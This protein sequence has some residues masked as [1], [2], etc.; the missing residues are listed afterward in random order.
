MQPDYLYQLLPAIY[1]QQDAAKGE[2]LRAL[3]GILQQALQNVY[4]DIATSYN[5]AFIETCA[6]WAIPYI[7]DLLGITELD[8]ELLSVVDQ[9]ARVANTIRYRRRKGQAAITEQVINSVT[10]W[11]A[12]LVEFFQKLAITQDLH[13]IRPGVG[14]TASIRDA[15]AMLALN[16]PFDQS[17]H[18][19]EICGQSR[20]LNYNISS[21][22][23]Y[24]W[25]LQ[26]NSIINSTVYAIDPKNKPGCYT[27]N[28]V[29]LDMP[30]FN[31][32]QSSTKVTQRASAVNLPMAISLVNLAKDFENN[33]TASNYYGKD[34]SIYLNDP[35]DTENTYLNNLSNIVA[36]DLSNWTKPPKGKVAIDPQLG[37]ICFADDITPPK[38]LQVNY[39]FGFG[40]DLGGGSYDRHTSMAS[41]D[42]NTFAATVAK[43]ESNNSETTVNNYP[44]INAAIAAWKANAHYAKAIIQILDN[45]IYQ[46]NINW[47][48]AAGNQLIIEAADGVRPCIIGNTDNKSVSAAITALSNTSQ[49]QFNGILIDATL[50]ISGPLQCNLTDSTLVPRLDR[51]SI[52]INAN[53]IASLTLQNSIVGA[54][55]APVSADD[56]PESSLQIY[57]SIIDGAKKAAIAADDTGNKSCSINL[58][59]ERSTIS[60]NVHIVKIDTISESI[61]VN[62]IISEKIDSGCV[63]YS[64]LTVD[65]VTP[66]RYRCQPE[67]S[68]FPKAA[69]R[70][71]ELGVASLDDLPEEQKNTEQAMI[72]NALLP[73][74]ISTR[75]GDPN[76]LQLSLRCSQYITT[77]AQDGSEMGAYKSQANSQRSANLTNI[78]NEFLPFGL[79]ANVFY[80]DAEALLK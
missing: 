1:R 25:R 74:F 56:V 47:E 69:Q 3:M 14:T 26:N 31:L 27:F 71:A 4:D 34:K 45:G 39:Q 37:R 65:S 32:P 76:Y 43:T 29:G 7:A 38:E 11:S 51:P 55:R 18:T 21:L 16:G 60:G 13:Y 2:P 36:L 40:G 42:T 59:A 44:S 30:L 10:G 70:A 77:G 6:S 8:N 46:E 22:G 12:S 54:I 66:P 78:L 75:Y 5:N 9:R 23:V 64:S 19:A 24:L 53:S 48:I 58:H 28:P 33:L 79:Q 50:R 67:L 57:D 61:I 49:L 62:K 52:V 15:H 41:A 63:R 17:A 72:L 35:A 20:A 73:I 80:A 68:Y